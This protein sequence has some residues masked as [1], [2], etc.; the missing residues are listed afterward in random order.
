MGRL[1]LRLLAA[2]LIGMAPLLGAGAAR[3]AFN[4]SQI[5]RALNAQRAAN[6][7][8]PVREDGAMAAGCA[9]YDRYV[10]RN[11]LSVADHHYESPSLPGYTAAGNHAAHTSVLGVDVGPRRGSIAGFGWA[12]GDPWDDAAFH[13]F[14]LMNP[15]L[16]V[17]GGDER[18]ARL[19]DGQWVTLEC[20]NTFAGPFRTPPAR[21]RT[22]FY[23]RSGSTIP[24]VTQ[25]QEGEADLGVAPGADGPTPVFVYFF[26]R[27]LRAVRLSSVTATLDGKPIGVSIAYAGGASGPSAAG[28]HA[29]LRSSAR[30]GSA[31]LS[32]N[33]NSPEPGCGV[34]L[35][36]P[37]GLKADENEVLRLLDDKSVI[38]ALWNVSP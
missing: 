17:S 2:G 13:L 37:P 24:A 21:A 10:I 31:S 29:Q 19:A 5:V 25:N 27:G 11:G 14:Q 9:A 22:Y 12:Y 38:H 32:G 8:P 15:A 20:V 34:E 18:T 30:N 35:H 7:I 6:G 4:S 36:V 26:G 33:Y 28:D 23:P 1:R 16:A 3:A